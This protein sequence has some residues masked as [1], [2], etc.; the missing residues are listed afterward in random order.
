LKED[1]GNRRQKRKKDAKDKEIDCVRSVRGQRKVYAA[2]LFKSLE[3]DQIEEDTR[4]NR[5]GRRSLREHVGPSRFG[6]KGAITIS[7]EA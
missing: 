7:G 3:K 6:S 1:W 4:G 2:R 5:E